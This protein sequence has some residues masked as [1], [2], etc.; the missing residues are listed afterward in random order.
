MSMSSN[1][2]RTFRL[3][4]YYNKQLMVLYSLKNSTIRYWLCSSHNFAPFNF[5][6]TSIDILIIYSIYATPLFFHLQDWAQTAAIRVHARARVEHMAIAE[7]ATT[8]P[9]GS[10]SQ[11]GSS[12]HQRYETKARMLFLFLPVLCFCLGFLL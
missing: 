5:N 10:R 4:I 12:S 6:L 7:C 11:L 1:F 8:G 9:S 3:N 2:K